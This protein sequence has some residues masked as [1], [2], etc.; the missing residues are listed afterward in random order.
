MQPQTAVD[1]TGD[2][3]AHSLSSI[4]GIT[5]CRWFQVSAVSIGSTSARIGDSN[6]TTTR[7]L[8][9]GAQSGQ[10]AP[11]ITQDFEPYDLTLWYVLVAS[12]DTVA[13]LAA[14]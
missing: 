9:I 3:A 12:S 2:G 14:F 1:F 5:K 10:F 11:A 7:G 8:P 6:I 13:V 4:L